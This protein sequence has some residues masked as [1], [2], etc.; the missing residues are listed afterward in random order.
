[1]PSEERCFNDLLGEYVDCPEEESE[2][3][4]DEP[5]D[6]GASGGDAI[7]FPLFEIPL[8]TREIESALS[9]SSEGELFR[10]IWKGLFDTPDT[11]P[12]NIGKRWYIPY[13]AVQN[14]LRGKV[15]F[16]HNAADDIMVLAPTSASLR[17]MIP[18]LREDSPDPLEESYELM[19]WVVTSH[20]IKGKVPQR[21]FDR[22]P[23]S[24][25]FLFCS[26]SLQ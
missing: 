18:A 9:S 10:D 1:M 23:V 25:L 22:V 4:K 5:E 6:R 12:L 21:I 26:D 8:M 11:V 7:L 24:Q 3:K 14:N 15:L 19:H 13:Q 16:T 2:D 17:A 20:L